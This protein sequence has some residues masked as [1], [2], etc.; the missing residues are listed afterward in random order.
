[1]A[2]IPSELAAD[3]GPVD[4]GAVAR[5]STSTRTS[6]S[7]T[8]V[9]RMVELRPLGACTNGR[10]SRVV[11][12]GRSSEPLPS[13][14]AGPPLHQ[15]VLSATA[16]QARAIR[17][18]DCLLPDQRALATHTKNRAPRAER[19]HLRLSISATERAASLNR[20]VVGIARPAEAAKANLPQAARAR[21]AA[22]EAHP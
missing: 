3:I 7:Q 18:F 1:M 2:P 5:L 17:G 11:A 13:R 9:T 8:S 21:S 10:A 15:R 6:H 20:T 16:H 19:G 12:T 14:L 4:R 22:T